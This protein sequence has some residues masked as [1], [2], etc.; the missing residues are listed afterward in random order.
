[1]RSAFSLICLPVLVFVSASS[2]HDNN[3]VQTT[4]TNHRT[5]NICSQNST[6]GL[7]ILQS[8]NLSYPGLSSV[9]SLFSAGD[10][11]GACE[12]LSQFYQQ[13]DSAGWLRYNV[14]VKP[15]NNTA[16]GAV[17][18]MVRCAASA[19]LASSALFFFLFLCVRDLSFS[20]SI[21][22]SVCRLVVG[23]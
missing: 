2:A 15:T 7:A 8:M 19:S 9:R 11:G 3:V 14:T 17:D 1:M 5:G 23:C 16:K 20:I 12:A 18:L 22:W 13:G 4:A 6:L 21:D 10:L